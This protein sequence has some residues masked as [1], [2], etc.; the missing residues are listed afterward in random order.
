MATIKLNG[1]NS[2]FVQLV[3]NTAAQNNTLT[4]PNVN[5]TLANITSPT[6]YSTN[7]GVAMV[8]DAN[9]NMGIGTSIPAY[10]LD[11]NGSARIGGSTSNSN[12]NFYINAGIQSQTTANW[13]FSNVNFIRNSSNTQN[14]RF[15]GML[16]DG[17]SINSTTIGAYNAIWG[18]YN[19]NP[20]TGSTSASLQG[21]MVYGAYYGHRWVLNGTEAMRITSTGNVGIATTTVTAP[22]HVFGTN[23]GTGQASPGAIIARF[24]D[25]LGR[26]SVTINGG[27][28]GNT[29]ATNATLNIGGGAALTWSLS[30]THGVNLATTFAG[31]GSTGLVVQ[32]YVGINDTSP[33]ANLTVGNGTGSTSLFVYG[34]VTG[35]KNSYVRL[36]D[37]SGSS[38]G[39]AAVLGGVT[40]VN[41]EGGTGASYFNGGGNVGIGSATPQQSLDVQGNVNVLNTVIMGSSFLRNRIINGAMQIDQRNAGASGTA[42]SVVT[43]DRWLYGATQASKGTWGQNLNSVTLPSGFSNY[44]GFQSSSAYTVLA[45]DQFFFRQAIEGNNFYDFGFGTAAAKT[46]TLSFVVYSSLTGTFSGSFTNYGF[47]RSYP[48]TYTISAAN[49]WT[50][51]YVT[52]PGD[53][54]G[55]WVGGTNAGAA[56][57]WFSL[58]IGSTYTGPASAWA[59]A[60][61]A[62]ATGATS[63]VGTS[64]ATFYITGVQLEQGPVA[65]PFER[66]LFDQILIDCQRYYE[67]SYDV[68]VV[69]GTSTSTNAFSLIASSS[70]V[71]YPAFFK[72]T[73]RIVNGT[74]T[75]YST[76]GASGN[77]R[78]NSAA[79]DLAVSTVTGSV[80]GYASSNGGTTNNEYIGQ[81]TIDAEI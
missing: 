7:S 77:I 14:P 26:N 68:T 16:L 70:L 6:F 71:R 8:I 78:N 67:K 62:A 50:T 25:G 53:T 48:F 44:L 49:T 43:V 75:F 61:Y 23:T 58:G 20:T 66:K 5:D 81:W 13:N 59:T 55:T 28:D 33:G 21:A 35:S 56:L 79:S 65:T 17:D 54:G 24:M 69:P 29:P 12:Q 36:T 19:A 37:T 80:N 45:G 41:I 52:I 57:V 60:S 3:A 63:V 22:L 1:T 38:I 76:T 46:I 15:I 18:S 30:T 10:L 4:L 47:T 40:K 32:G 39:L 11:V 42:I 27:I 2:G 64:G 34:N 9:G 51:V 72:V 73:K 31:S 74:I